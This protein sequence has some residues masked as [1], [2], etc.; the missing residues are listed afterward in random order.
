MKTVT[1]VEQVIKNIKQFN[2]EATSL[3]THPV[4]SDI[5][6]LVNNIPHYRAWYCFFD[7][8]CND[9]IFAPSKYIGYSE[10]DAKTYAEYNRNGL[11]GRKTESVLSTWY[12]TM[13]DS[14]QDYE[15]LCEKLREFCVK[16]EKKPNSLF[17]INVPCTKSAK[18]TLEE[19][20]VE[21]IWNAYQNLSS[22]SRRQIKNKIIKFR[23]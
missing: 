13:S 15:K 19:D 21:F 23:D 9:Y 22:D 2:N 6:N 18:S 3:L 20:V 4:S 17:R 14:H 11:D 1:N 12:E 16:F 10:I 7:E 8:D 5:E